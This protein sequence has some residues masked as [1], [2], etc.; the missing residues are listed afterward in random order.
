MEKLNLLLAVMFLE[1]DLA[2]CKH[3]I[4]CRVFPR[5]GWWT[6]LI[7][8]EQDVLSGE[9][10]QKDYFGPGGDSLV[11]FLKGSAKSNSALPHQSVNVPL[12]RTSGFSSF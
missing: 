8:T 6:P 2:F 3:F 5:S 4:N 10:F 7:L 1:S 12:N 9:K 11:G